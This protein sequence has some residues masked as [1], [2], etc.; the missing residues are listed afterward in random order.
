[1]KH[2]MEDVYLEGREANG[3]CPSLAVRVGLLLIQPTQLEQEMKRSSSPSASTAPP[4]QFAQEV[5]SLKQ[6]PMFVEVFYT[7]DPSLVPFCTDLAS[8]QLCS[9]GELSRRGK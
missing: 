4:M 7:H 3:V 9:M 1:M 2:A 8:L 6:N 5:A